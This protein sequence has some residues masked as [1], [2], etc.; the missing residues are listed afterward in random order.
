MVRETRHLWV[1]NLPENI[2]EDRIRDHFK[3]Y[4]RVQSVKLLPRAKDDEGSG[5]CAT[6]SFMDIKSASKAHNNEQKLE[7]RTLTTEYHEPAAI[8]G[9]TAPIYS[10]QRFSHGPPEEIS[11]FERSSHFYERERERR[12]GDAYLRRAS[13]T[14]HVPAAEPLRG[15]TRD[16]H[17]RNGPYAPIIESV[18]S[19]QPPHHR[20]V[21]SSWSYDSSSR[22]PPPST[23]PDVYGDDRRDLTPVVVVHKKHAKSRSGSN[24]SESGSNSSSVSRSR[25][26]S[27]SSQSGSSSCSSASSSPTSDKSCSTHS[28]HGSLR[29]GVTLQSAVSTPHTNNS[30]P[31]VHSDDRRPLAICVRNLPARS[32]DTSLKDGLFHEYKKHGKVTWVKVVGQGSDRYALVCF[33]KPDD[34]EKALLVSHDKLF[35]GCKI[36]VAAYQGYDVDDNEFRFVARP[37]EAEQDEFHPKATRTLFIGN[38]EKD[39]TAAELRK[40]FDQFG[41][42]IEIDIKKQ[43]STSSYAFCQYCDISS[44]VRAMRTLDG[45]HLGNNRIK[46][47]FGKSLHTNCVWVDGVAESVTEKYLSLQFSQFGPVSHVVIDRSRGHALVFYDQLGFAQSAVKDM[48]GVAVRGRKLQVDFASRECQEAFYD[49]LE[50]QTGHNTTFETSVQVSPQATTGAPVRG[51]ETPSSSSSSSGGGGS[52]RYPRYSTQPQAARSYSRGAPTTA[53]SPGTSPARSTPRHV[54]TTPR[55]DFNSDFIADRR[56][57]RS[58]EEMSLEDGGGTVTVT[59]G[60]G[61]QDIRHLQKERVALLEQLE[62]C[63]SSGEEGSSRR[64]CKHRRSHS[65]EGSRPG[66]PLCDERPENLPPLEPRRTPRERPPDPLSLPLPRFATQLMS[67]RPAPRSPPASP[68]R[69]QSTSSDDSE[70][71]PPSPEWEERLR[72]LDEKY[73]KWSGSRSIMTKV[74]PATLRVRHKLLDLDLNELQPS[75]IVKSVLAKRSVFDEDSK[76]LENF[77]E[78]YEPREFVPS[79]PGFST[80]R[81]RMDSPLLHSPAAPKSPAAASSPA[82]A[83][84]LQYPFPSHPPVQP[85]TSVATTTAPMSLG[86]CSSLSSVTAISPNVPSTESS[87]SQTFPTTCITSVSSVRQFQPPTTTFH[88]PP[89]LSSPPSVEK[90][91]E[92]V[93]PRLCRDDK[94]KAPPKLLSPNNSN[95]EKSDGSMKEP[96]LPSPT[97]KPLKSCLRRESADDRIYD[98]GRRLSRD[99]E[100]KTLKSDCEKARDPESFERR[101]SYSDPR[102]RDSMDSNKDS[103]RTESVSDKLKDRNHKEE[104]RRRDSVDNSVKKDS[105]IVEPF[106]SRLS[107]SRASEH[108]DI[109]DCLKSDPLN[110]NKIFDSRHNDNTRH[111]TTDTSE[112]KKDSLQVCPERDRRRGRESLDTSSDSSRNSK[113][114]ENLDDK[115]DVD[116]DTRQKDN[117]S[118]KSDSLT[119]KSVDYNEKKKECVHQ[120]TQKCNDS[121]EKRKEKDTLHVYQENSK[122]KEKRDQVKKEK[123]ATDFT[124]TTRHK[125]SRKS[126]DSLDSLRQKDDKSKSSTYMENSRHKENSNRRESES[127]ED[128]SLKSVDIKK[129][130]DNLQNIKYKDSSHIKDHFSDSYHSACKSEE[131]NENLKPKDIR[132]D[133]E[134]TANSRHRENSKHFDYTRLREDEKKRDNGDSHIIQQIDVKRE[135]AELMK[136]KFQELNKEADIFRHL[137]QPNSEYSS[138]RFK[139]YDKRRDGEKLDFRTK[140]SEIPL[141]NNIFESS[142]QKNFEKQNNTDPTSQISEWVEEIRKDLENSGYVKSR[143]TGDDYDENSYDPRKN[144]ASHSYDINHQPIEDKR[145][146]GDPKSKQGLKKEDETDTL[147]KDSEKKKINNSDYKFYERRKNADAAEIFRRKEFARKKENFNDVDSMKL[148]EIEKKFENDLLGSVGK[149]RNVGDKKRDS[150]DQDRHRDAIDHNELNHQ[151]DWYDEKHADRKSDIGKG[152]RIIREIDSFE[153][154]CESD[155]N[156]RKEDGESIEKKNSSFDH[157]EDDDLM[158]RNDFSKKEKK[159]E[160][161]WPAAI[162]SKRRL[163]SQDSLEI[164]ADDSKKSKPERRDSKDSGRS[165]TSSKK[166]TSEKHNKSFAKMLEEKIKEDKEK[167]LCKKRK[168]DE[169]ESMKMFKKDK[170]NSSEKRKE[171]RKGK[172]KHNKENGITA[173]ESEAGSGDDD[174]KTPKRH[175][176]FDIVDE[177]PAYIS[178]YD[179]VKARSTKNM[180]KQEEEKR[181]ERLKEKFNQLKQSRA[182]REEKKRSTSYDEDSDSERGGRRSNKLMITSSEEDVNSEGDIRTKGRKIMSDTSEDDCH[183][184]LNL[185]RLKALKSNAED[186][187][188][189]PRKIMSDTSEDD[190]R[191]LS[192]ARIKVPRPHQEDLEPKLRKILSDTSEDD[193]MK[194]TIVRNKPS[195]IQSDESEIDLSFDENKKGDGFVKKSNDYPTA[196]LFSNISEDPEHPTQTDIEKEQSEQYHRNSIDSSTSDL[197]RKKSHKK[198]QKRQKNSDDPEDGNGKRHSSKKDRRKSSHSHDGDEEQTEKTKV[199]KK[200]SERDGSSKRDDKMEDIFGPLSD[201]SDKTHNNKWHV[202][203]IYGSDS[204]DERQVIRKRDKR[205]KERKARELDEAGRALEAKLLENSDGF[206]PSEDF[207][208]KVKKKKRKKS[209]EEKMSKHHQQRLEEEAAAI[210]NEADSEREPEP[211]APP[212]SLPRLMDSP[213][214]PSINQSKKPDIPGFGS[215]VDENIHETAVKSISESPTKPI[216][217]KREPIEEPIP[218]SNSEDKPT[219]VISQ[220]ETEDAVAA[221]LLEDS[222]GGGFESYTKPDTPVS[223]PDLQID[224][225]TEDNYDPIDFSRPPRTPDIP[226]SFYRQQDTREG[227]EERILALACPDNSKQEGSQSPASSPPTIHIN[228]Y[229]HSD[230]ENKSSDDKEKESS[231][232]SFRPKP[233]NSESK[234]INIKADDIASPL[235]EDRCDSVSRSVDAPKRQDLPPLIC[236]DET[237]QSPKNIVAE[238][239]SHNSAEPKTEA[240]ILSSEKPIPATPSQVLSKPVPTPLPPPLVHTSNQFPKSTTNETPSVIFSSPPSAPTETARN[241]QSSHSPLNHQAVFPTQVEMNKKQALPTPTLQDSNIDKSP[242]PQ[243]PVSQIIVT[244]PTSVALIVQTQ[245]KLPPSNQQNNSVLQLA[246]KIHSPGAQHVDVKGNAQV[247]QYV[248][249]HNL[250]SPQSLASQSI[251]NKTVSSVNH[252]NFPQVQGSHKLNLPTM[253]VSAK[254]PTGL[255][256]PNKPMLD[257]YKQIIANQPHSQQLSVNVSHNQHLNTNVLLSPSQQLNI[258][259]SSAQHSPSP[260]HSPATLSFSPHH[261]KVSL[262][263]QQTNNIHPAMLQL[264]PNVHHQQMSPHQQ[265]HIQQHSPVLQHANKNNSNL[266]QQVPNCIPVKLCSPTKPGTGHTIRHLSPVSQPNSINKINAH[267]LQTSCVQQVRA[268][269]LQNPSKQTVTVLQPQIVQKTIGAQMIRPL[270]APQPQVVHTLKNDAPVLDK[271]RAS[272]ENIQNPLSLKI[273]TPSLATKAIP[274]ITEEPLSL[275][276]SKKDELHHPVKT[277]KLTTGETVIESARLSAVETKI[278]KPVIEE[279][280]PLNAVIQDLTAKVSSSPSQSQDSKTSNSATLDKVVQELHDRKKA[281]ESKDPIKIEAD[282]D[283]LKTKVEDAPKINAEM[284]IKKDHEPNL[285]QENT[286]HNEQDLKS[287]D[288]KIEPKVET[289]VDEPSKTEIE[290]PVEKPEISSDKIVSKSTDEP[291]IEKIRIKKEENGLCIESSSSFPSPKVEKSKV[292]GQDE[293]KAEP[294]D[295]PIKHSDEESTEAVDIKE[296]KDI[297]GASVRGRGGRRRKASGRGGGVVTRRARLNNNAA[298]ASETSA[299]VY[300]FRDDSEEEANRP[301]LILTIKSPQDPPGPAT[302]TAP[303]TAASVTAAQANNTRK[304]RRLQVSNQEKDG[305]SRTTVDDT[306]EDVIRGTRSGGRRMT[307]ASATCA[308]SAVAAQA[309]ET[310]K[311]PRRKQCSAPP[312]PALDTPAAEVKSVVTPVEPAAPA[313]PLTPPTALHTPAQPPSTEPMTLIDPVTGLLIP[314]RESEEGQYIPVNTD[315]VRPQLEGKEDSGE[316]AEKRMRTSLPTDTESSL[317]TRPGIPVKVPPNCAVVPPLPP[318]TTPKPIASELSRPII[319][320]G[321]PQVTKTTG[322]VVPSGIPRPT[323]TLPSSVS[324]SKPLTIAAPSLVKPPQG[325]MMSPTGINNKASVTNVVGPMTINRVV[326]PPPPLSPSAKALPTTPLSHKTHLLQAVHRQKVPVAGK[327]PQPMTPKAHILHSISNVEGIVGAGTPPPPHHGPLLTGSVASP[328]LRAHSQQPVVTGASSARV[329]CKGGLLEPL[330]VEP[331]GCIVVPS[332]SPQTRSQVM[333]AGLPVPAYEAS[334]HGLVAELLPNPQWPRQSP[335]PAHQPQGD[336]VQHVN[337]PPHHIQPA[338]YV[339]PQLVYQQYLREAALTGYH[340]PTGVK[341]EIEEG[342]R[343]ALELRRGSPHDRTTDSPQVATVYVHGPRHLYYEPPPAHRPSHAQPR[344][345]VA[346]PPHASQVPPQ[347]DSLLMLLQR[348]PVMWQGLLALK[349]DQAAVQMHFVFGNP[350]VARDSLPC[351][352]D[353]STPPLRIAQ[354]MRLEQTQVEGVARKMQMDAEHCMLLALPCGRDHMDVLQQSNN[355]QSGFITYLQQKQAAG[356]VNIA[357]PGSQQAAYVVH[358]F[359]SCDFANES[360]ARIAPDLLHRVANIAHLLIVIAT[361]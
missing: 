58:Y 164:S 57:Y 290:S 52:A 266:L 353:G 82:G 128:L 174:S 260:H 255:I 83:K 315:H 149:Q 275:T 119:R 269:V 186:V 94:M 295:E 247:S 77:G 42:I 271:N 270:N 98:S 161:F 345:Q 73:E 171:D 146:E 6:V 28:H 335:P 326:A 318:K 189:K 360:L 214:P 219:P 338:H 125:S 47:G 154:G 137:K 130:N 111:T 3:R 16:R 304:S 38:L 107:E 64:R 91:H 15:R 168:E 89:K 141:Q 84:G 163:S 97:L 286:S 27:S 262:A 258:N 233:I 78:K 153:K 72:S 206:P 222:F 11:S 96:S 285:K 211:I 25:S 109:S 151:R 139:E 172:P 182:K 143:D 278:I 190:T 167:E 234:T 18:V 127:S 202:S 204:E 273:E 321:K 105:E 218:S 300:E 8:P 157:H 325:V 350:H 313:K 244:P 306:I 319:S 106:K 215:Q 361:V 71:S 302:T 292:E 113:V 217:E 328:P 185:P 227:L 331:G 49:H 220:E 257:Q 79:R 298:S 144:D 134:F 312:L 88:Q 33:K 311:S 61:P 237:Y 22:Y 4:G 129:E 287:E 59:V 104:R 239:S 181:Q 81:P 309:L 276:T 248:L 228:E 169:A 349:T 31:A 142:K 343:D 24:G 173:S 212:P 132:K 354:R 299:D 90:K 316:P 183:R 138:H 355:L 74:D 320:H 282:T 347:A 122:H 120:E 231:N 249:H 34:V 356:I 274:K 314:M 252:G 150:C 160:N 99:E 256:V 39:I 148:K 147:H 341:G 108:S 305:V 121:S 323:S 192:I 251:S 140:N 184:N 29:S 333:Q 46:L 187:E 267:V 65:G 93:D 264:S 308:A 117:V 112:K 280:K 259:H 156:D 10:S 9:S 344:L 48:R 357:G 352:S 159:R 250:Q 133:Q 53:V 230:N 12:D 116:C 20:S 188:I 203:Q 92:N 193:V 2:R 291:K 238:S 240:R 5:V 301:R 54:T 346:T 296:N 35:F 327:V 102:R 75:E 337:F 288:V 246:N 216:E 294:K 86:T 180:Q 1:G 118:D 40:H 60:Q 110:L 21:G 158:R 115:K 242:L 324:L 62:D 114:P 45:E 179:K 51:F 279:V 200:K 348:Y 310:R 195:R 30:S 342:A 175:S 131:F 332:A 13:S 213:P 19:R 103:L 241:V 289:T 281:V 44:V 358:I 209:R 339:H 268:V 178:M 162:G 165:S 191:R 245:T 283:E 236:K 87:K 135:H 232:S 155:Q 303:A 70:P 152:R 221:L 194:H 210:A 55:F 197:P 95:N 223:E 126:P 334:M 85:T 50:K 56:P 205:R 101:R 272:S 207:K 226:T 284:E 23:T 199:R 224:T 17:Y 235:K 229:H 124:E 37:Y 277:E 66:T 41:E 208:E 261:V 196:D 351:N 170:K 254:S 166:S 297:Q 123:E 243:K 253:P 322:I 201:D 67:P 336:V 26:S 145:K 263:Q 69:P 293:I 36:E 177:E 7:D 198:K 76:R 43:G 68:P 330:K 329:V 340:L 176:I 14:Y 80:L 63:A 32:S 100:G 136:S 359:P 307:R 265:K 317:P 225:D